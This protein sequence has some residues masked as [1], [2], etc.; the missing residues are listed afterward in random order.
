M[1]VA[2]LLLVAQLSFDRYDLSII[3]DPP[4]RPGHNWIGPLGA[5]IAYYSFFIFGF[6]AYML[7]LLLVAFGLAYWLE[8]LAYLKRRWLWAAVLLLS[9]MGWLHLLDLPHLQDNAS[10][11]SRART[12]IAAPSIGGFVGRTLHDY[13]F[14]MLGA[15]GAAI[16][17]GRASCRERV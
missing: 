2:L 6:S 7:P 12:A 1:A 11:I 8:A 3:R 13:F 9:C 17:I 16:E 10:F 15:V 4:N 5:W 14:W